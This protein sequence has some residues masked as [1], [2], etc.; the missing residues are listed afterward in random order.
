MTLRKRIDELE[1]KTGAGKS[2]EIWL[3]VVY[4]DTGKPS[5]AALEVAKSEYKAKHPDR[6]GRDFNVIWVKTNIPRN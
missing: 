1:K 6:Q 2:D 4:D 3:V 5:E